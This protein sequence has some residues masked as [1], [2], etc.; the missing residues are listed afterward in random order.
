MVEDTMFS[1]ETKNI[2]YKVTL[3]EKSEKYMKTIIAFANS[4][5]GKLI[6]GVDDKTCQITGVDNNTL[7]QQMDAIANA[8]S[9]SCMPQ[10]IPDI[11]PQTVDGKTVIVVTVEAGKNRPYYLKSKGKENGTYVRVAGTSRQAF[12]E[13]IKELE[14]EGARISWDELTCVGYPVTEEATQKLC[15]DIESFRKKAGMSEHIVQ[16]EQLMNWKIL[17]TSEGGL[18]ATNAYALLTSDYFPFSKTQC[19]VFKGTDRTIFLDKREFTGPIYKQIEE[20]V[21]F[22]LR[23]IRL[24]ATIDGLVRKEKY[25]LPP[26]A[27][28]EMIINAQ[29]HRNLL[30]EAC[31]Q[32]AVYDDRLE[33]TS[34]G[35]LYNGLTYKEVMSGHSKIRNKAIA[36]IFSQ[37]GLV[38]AWGSGIKRIFNA[39]KEY[40]LKEPKIEEF[41]NMFR[42]EL[43]RENS[44]PRPQKQNIEVA[45]EKYAKNIEKISEK[46]RG[47]IGE[48]SEEKWKREL[49]D[50]QQKIVELLLEDSKLSAAK[51][52]KKIGV[53]S[54]NIEVNIKKLKEHGI[55]IRHGSPKSG[56]WEV[57][58]KDI[59]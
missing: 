50:T 21:D 1:G 55:L 29:C 3:P 18:L 40:G 6:I 57:C 32:V 48:T 45:S 24:G 25:E 36:N 53:A 42:V 41:D 10:I 37:M 14:M 33:V 58:L 46:H 27:I 34:P 47:N 20:A 2:E 5:G 39:A 7:F 12:P 13:K 15:E 19:A 4:Q 35:G 52:S 30:E 59:E 56:Y 49:N 43:F 11:E 17:K 28:R 31:I 51:L 8:V 22:V 16:K 26:E 54:R 23:N 44:L 38:E 9:D